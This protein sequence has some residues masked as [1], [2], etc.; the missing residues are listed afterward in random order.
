MDRLATEIGVVF[1][2]DDEVSA[3]YVVGGQDTVFVIRLEKNDRG[4]ECAGEVPGM[5]LCEGKIV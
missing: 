1:V 3:I 2:E 5:L 4:H